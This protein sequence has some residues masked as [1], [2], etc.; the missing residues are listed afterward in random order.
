ML[1]AVNNK[2]M[3]GSIF[4]DLEKAFNSVNHALLL[5]KL[6][7]YGISSKAKLLLAAYLQN[8]Y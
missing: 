6:P 3:D 5:S 4:L 1:N 7:Y 8:R 2:T